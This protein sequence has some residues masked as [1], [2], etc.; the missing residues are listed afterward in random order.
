MTYAIDDSNS[1]PDSWVRGSHFGDIDAQAAE[2]QGYDQ[3]Y[4]QLSRGPFV[5]RCRSFRF[6]DDLAINFETAN[7]TLS[8]S[9][10]TPLGRYGACILADGSPS[11]VLN[12]ASVS[13][14]N[15]VLCSEGNSLEGQTPEGFKI[16]CLDIARDLLPEGGCDMATVG[17]S[18]DPERAWQL[19]KLVRDGIDTFTALS[20]PRDY[21]AAAQGFKSALVDLLWRAAAQP[22]DVRTRRQY[23]NAR[24]LGVFRRARDLI[25]HSLC[26]GISIAHLCREAG[27]SRRSLEGVFRCVIGVSPAS[28]IRLLQLNFIR[29][30]LLS[31]VSADESIGAIA[32]RYGVWHWS[33]FS[34]YYR[35]QFGEL[36][37]ATRLRRAA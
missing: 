28:Y 30:E 5:G 1:C 9:A 6:G 33:R 18:G 16:F 31:G 11:C 34:H 7:R 17:M 35:L 27:V 32:A 14:D 26:D 20:G 2:Y 13:P 37:S 12:A 36:P 29:R 4:Q 25:H 8:Q 21:P 22:G 24:A 3:R 15:I 23:R 19:R 10:S